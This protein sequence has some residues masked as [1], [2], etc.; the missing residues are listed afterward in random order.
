M[1]IAARSSRDRACC[2]R[3]TVSARSKYAS[4]FAAS[5]LGDLRTT[6]P[7]TRLTSA[8]NH[9]ALAPIDGHT[10]KPRGDHLDGVVEFARQEQ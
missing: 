2:L 10:F 5:D 3:V 6:S 1:L 9:R 8:S 7:A 4:A